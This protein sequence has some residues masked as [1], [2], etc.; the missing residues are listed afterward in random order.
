MIQS[1]PKAVRY[2]Y[3]HR[4]VPLC[5]AFALRHVAASAIRWCQNQPRH[6]PASSWLDHPIRLKVRR[7][8]LL[9]IKLKH[10]FQL[11]CLV[12]CEHTRATARDDVGPPARRPAVARSSIQPTPGW[13]TAREPRVLPFAAAG[14]PI[15]W[16]SE[17]ILR[18]REPIPRRR[19][20]VPWRSKPVPAAGW[21]WSAATPWAVLAL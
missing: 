4:L 1:T 11:Q 17:P 18:R 21:L 19:E 6:S 16:R 20:P 14:W 7:F 2:L 5:S 3:R 13:P 15:P 12:L 8:A 10:C 9:S